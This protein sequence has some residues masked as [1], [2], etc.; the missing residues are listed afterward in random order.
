MI[1]SDH[2]FVLRHSKDERMVFSKID[3]C[4]QPTGISEEKIEY[5]DGLGSENNLFRAAQEGS[6]RRF[7][8]EGIK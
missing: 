4:Y 2:P 3:L 6:V 8:D 1:S 5:G 7:E